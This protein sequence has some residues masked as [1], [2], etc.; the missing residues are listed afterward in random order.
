MSKVK[1]IPDG[2]H[3]VTVYLSVEGAVRAIEFYAKAFGAKERMRLATPD[4]RI[5]HAEIAIGDSIVMLTDAI[6]E[7]VTSAS[8]YLYVDNVDAVYERA[9]AAGA[10]AR[11]PVTDMFWGDRYCKMT[12]PFGHEWSIATHVQDLSP[13]QIATAQEA[14]FA[15]SAG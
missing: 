1:S 2:F 3:T 10:E 12:D 7:P 5:A 15:Q 11:M 8:I 14:F 13:E 6:R 9:I 4:G